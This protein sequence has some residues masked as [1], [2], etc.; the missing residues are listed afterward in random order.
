MDG[1]G[2]PSSPKLP[3]LNPSHNTLCGTAL[4]VPAPN[5]Y[6]ALTLT[7]SHAEDAPGKL[8]ATLRAVGVEGSVPPQDR[9]EGRR[10]WGIHA[11]LRENIAMCFYQFGAR[12]QGM[13]GH[14]VHH[15]FFMPTAM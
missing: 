1:S 11:E 3:G 15:S 10:V 14:S 12:E 8:F 5:L 7:L 13:V 2:S 6:R 9:D 4:P